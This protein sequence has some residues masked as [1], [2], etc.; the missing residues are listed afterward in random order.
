MRNV[1]DTNDPEKLLNL[2]KQE[3]DALRDVIRSMNRGSLKKE[4][5]FKIAQN[6]LL[7][8]IGVRKMMFLFD[9]EEEGLRTGLRF[10]LP[11]IDEQGY[12]ELPR[13]LGAFE[14]NSEEHP[15]LFEMGVEYAVAVNFQDRVG[16]WFLV[17]NFAESEAEKNSDLIFIDTMGNVLS[18][19]VENRILMRKMLRQESLRR[20]LEVAEKIQR[21]LLISDFSEVKGADIA[22]ENVA[23]HKIGGDFYDVIPRG[24]KG[25]FVCIADVAGKGIGAALLMANLQANLRALILSQNKLVDVIKK[26]HLLLAEITRGEQ[27]I[28]LFLA[29]VRIQEREIDY[30]N[31]GH[32]HP[33]LLHKGKIETLDKGTIPLGIIDLGLIEEE[34]VSYHPGDTFFLFT[35]GLIEQTNPDGEFLGDEVVAE[36]LKDIAELPSASIVEDMS[37]FHKSY[38]AGAT[39]DDDVTL[40]SVKFH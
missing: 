25:F 1:Y 32:N 29:H 28:T 12:N 39:I 30:I 36:R 7:A 27:F 11:E 16:A 35:D 19:A 24:D 38:A 2:K 5:I 31:A 34:T 17:A 18:T 23:H 10:G 9:S 13:S 20:E 26:L 33:M 21:Q 37:T 14:V 3:A 6:T 22:A 15:R 4:H 40:M 8:Q